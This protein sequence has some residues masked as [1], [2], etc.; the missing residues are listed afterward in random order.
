MSQAAPSTEGIDADC[1]PQV[2]TEGGNE[3]HL[4]ISDASRTNANTMRGSKFCG[5]SLKDSTVS[6]KSYLS[7]FGPNTTI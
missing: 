4:T 5:K 7:C 1:V 2:P 6:G 3:D